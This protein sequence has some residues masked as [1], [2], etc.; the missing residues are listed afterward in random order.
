[1]PVI[2]QKFIYRSDLREN[3]RVLYV[4]G[5]NAARIGLGGQAKEMR[6]EPNA[7]GVA[8][9]WRSGMNTHD[10]FYDDQFEERTKGIIDNDFKPIVK[11]LEQ[12]RIVIIPSDGLGTG[13]SQLPQRAP[14]TYAYIEQHIAELSSITP[15]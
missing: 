12:G 6:G 13:F 3:P 15:V 2:R 8:T 7:L 10:F 11:A 9:K 4:F 1:M 5:D 14:A